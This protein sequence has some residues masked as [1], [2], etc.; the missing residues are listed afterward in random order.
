MICT[1]SSLFNALKV[2][3]IEKF[4]FQFGN[5]LR[6]VSSCFSLLLEL[7]SANYRQIAFTQTMNIH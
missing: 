3:L 1:K 7:L 2:K 5:R 4:E 6:G